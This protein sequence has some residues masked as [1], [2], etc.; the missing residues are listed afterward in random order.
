MKASETEP[1]STSPTSLQRISAT[2]NVGYSEREKRQAEEEQKEEQEEEQEEEE[3][4]EKEE[5]EMLNE[6]ND[7]DGK[8]RG[9]F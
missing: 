6:R 7:D 1:H 4:E 8:T 9:E 3:K 2:R 5:K